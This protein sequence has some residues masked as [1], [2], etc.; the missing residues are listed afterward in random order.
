MPDDITGAIKHIVKDIRGHLTHLGLDLSM[1]P[2]ERL[3]RKH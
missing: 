3:P 2:A 1:G